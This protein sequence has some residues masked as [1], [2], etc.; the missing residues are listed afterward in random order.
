M[1]IILTADRINAIPILQEGQINGQMIGPLA[2]PHYILSVKS[3]IVL[4]SFQ[5]VGI[6]FLHS[7]ASMVRFLG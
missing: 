6:Y 1:L 7:D 4:Y 2:E 5:G 3:L